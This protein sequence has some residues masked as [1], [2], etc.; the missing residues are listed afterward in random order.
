MRVV[1]L[2]LGQLAGCAGRHAVLTETPSTASPA[3]KT[4]PSSPV[5]AVGALSDDIILIGDH[6]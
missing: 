4:H 1:L 5:T 2:G 3:A 6:G